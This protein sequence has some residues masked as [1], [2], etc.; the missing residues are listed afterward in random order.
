M[1]VKVLCKTNAIFKKCYEKR[2]DCGN[3]PVKGL[4]KNAAVFYKAFILMTAAATALYA[5]TIVFMM[6]TGN[7]MDDT[8][9][10]SNA[11]YILGVIFMAAKLILL[12]V[13]SFGKDLGKRNTWIGFCVILAL[14]LIFGMFYTTPGRMAAYRFVAVLPRLLMDGTIGLAIRGKYD[15]KDA[16]GTV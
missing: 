1:N 2:I 8:R 15:D 13:M 6:Q 12:L 5:L 14:D 7:L 9:I 16:R 3:I 11:L 4:Q 10:T